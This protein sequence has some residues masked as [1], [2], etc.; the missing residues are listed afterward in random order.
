MFARLLDVLCCRPTHLF[1]IDRHSEQNDTPQTFLNQWFQETLDFVDTPSLLP[2][3]RRNIHFGVR[4][5]GYKDGIHEH[6][7]GETSSL[8]LITP[9]KRVVIAA[10]KDRAVGAVD[11]RVSRFT[12]WPVPVR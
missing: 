10:G 4:V 12:S 5:V 8:V 9:Q 1:D 2:R 11:G 7:L 6:I 3:Q